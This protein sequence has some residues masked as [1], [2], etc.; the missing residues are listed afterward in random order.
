MDTYETLLLSIDDGVA[1]LT[2]NRPKVLNAIDRRMADELTDALRA[3]QARD[4]LCAL[5][6]H[7]AG[8]HFCAGGDVRGMR[9]TGPRTPAEAKRGM[10]RYRRMTE[11]LHGFDRPVIAAIDGV[12]FGAGFSLALLADIVLLGE[13]A[14]LS[15]VFGRVGLIPDCGALYTLPRNI[16]LQRAKEL[17]FSAREIG[18]AEALRLGLALEVLPDD[19]LLDRAMALASTFRGASPL[20]LALAKRALDQSQHCDLST[21]LDIEAAGQA[22]AMGSEYHAD[23]VQR[24]VAKEPLRFNA[25]PLHAVD[26]DASG[27]KDGLTHRI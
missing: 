8:G 3:L 17:V 12:A 9:D 24:F 1:R 4:D 16:G 26:K 6:L 10:E 20:A 13:R 21:L 23:A 5:V 22:L 19:A 11:A 18:A 25:E 15:L 7:G 27:R 2:L 14:R